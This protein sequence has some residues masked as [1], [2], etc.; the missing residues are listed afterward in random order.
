MHSR[1]TGD[2]NIGPGIDRQQSIIVNFQFTVN[3]SANACMR[4]FVTAIQ[5]WPV[6]PMCDVILVGRWFVMVSVTRV[7]FSTKNFHETWKEKNIYEKGLL[8]SS[9]IVERT[10]T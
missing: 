7:W 8:S 3:E 4:F 2:V 1:I 5:L 10:S 9:Q 6:P